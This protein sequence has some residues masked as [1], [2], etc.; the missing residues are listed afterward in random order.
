MVIPVIVVDEGRSDGQRRRLAGLP[1][2]PGIAPVGLALAWIDN[3]ARLAITTWGSSSAPSV[4]TTFEVEGQRLTLIL[5]CRN[6]G[7]GPISADLSP[8]VTVIDAPPGLDPLAHAVVH[9][10]GR[11]Y[12]LPPLHDIE[13]PSI[14]IHPASRPHR[15]EP[16]R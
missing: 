12:D 16:D 10:G 4:P 6:P 8:Y 14:S 9:S 13:P 2:R 3:G 7:G 1:P 11:D 15:L 5:A